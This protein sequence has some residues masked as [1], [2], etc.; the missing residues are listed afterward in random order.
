MY[1]ARAGTV[2]LAGLVRQPGRVAVLD[3]LRAR[4][5]HYEVVFVLGLDEG[6]LPRRSPPP[7]LLD[8]DARLRARGAVAPGP[9]S[10][11]PDPVAADRYLFYT[12]CTRATRRLYLVSRGRDRRRFAARAEPVLGGR[13]A[14]SSRDR[15]R[16]T[17]DEATLR[18][19][20]DLAG[21]SSRRPSASALRATAALAAVDPEATTAVARA[22]GWDRRLDRALGA[23]SGPTRLTHP[24]VLRELAGRADVRR[25]GAGAVRRLLVDVVRRARHR[26]AGDRRS[27][28]RT[29]ARPGCAPGAV[30]ALLG[31]AEA[32]RLRPRRGRAARRDARVPRRVRREAVAGQTSRL[33]L[34]GRRAARAR[35]GPAPRPR[36]VRAVGGASPRCRSCRGGS[37]CRSAAE[38]SA[39]E[40]QGRA[41]SR[42]LRVSGKI[43][44]VDLDPFSARGI[45]QDYKS[46]KGAHSAAKIESELRLQIPLYMLVLRDL[47][48]VEPIGGLYRALAGERSARGVLRA[49]R[50][51]RRRARLR[52]ARLPRRRRV[53]GGVDQAADRARDSSAG[54]GRETSC[55]TRR[56]VRVPS[57]CELAPICRVRRP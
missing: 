13:D 14:R 3:M 38:R 18:S 55:T 37:R 1:D 8:D 36:R 42:R 27:R 29:T 33:E 49:E 4:T 51:R 54:S 31:P 15:G 9:R 23:F 39:P 6:T 20:G 5:R 22:N 21:R 17:L 48:G 10:T 2:T 45:V 41:R 57:W 53:L 16:R 35:A 47:L 24:V 7:T 50:A 28:R 30:P 26:S 44:R 34:D 11:R 52:L 56:A 19:A 25:H 32:D 46:G 12:A 40:L 43:D